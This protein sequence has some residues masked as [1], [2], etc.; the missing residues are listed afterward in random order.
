ME[1]DVLEV[2]EEAQAV[3]L[4]A[5]HEEVAEDHLAME[6]GDS[7]AS[8]DDPKSLEGDQVG[9]VDDEGREGSLVAEE[10]E[11]KGP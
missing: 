5:Y 4:E 6:E 9:V 3:D 10:A 7:V 11:V 8:H 1:E 2:G